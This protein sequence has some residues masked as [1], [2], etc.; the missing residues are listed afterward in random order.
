MLRH[1]E[2][3]VAPCPLF[4][5]TLL[6]SKVLGFKLQTTGMQPILTVAQREALKGVVARRLPANP[7]IR[8]IEAYL[9]P[10]LAEQMPSGIAL[11]IA[12][13]VISTALAQKT[14]DALV[15]IIR[16]LDTHDETL[17]SLVKLA[18]DLDNGTIQWQISLS[19]GTIDWTV[20]GDPL[21]V[22]DGRPFVD[23]AGFRQLLPRLGAIDTP[24]CI[25][26]KGDYGYGKSYLQEY[27]KM[28]ARHWT[29][30]GENRMLRVGISEFRSGQ[31]SELSP[32][33]PAREL[34]VG[35][36]LRRPPKAHAD[37]HRYARNLAAWIA[38]E[39]P[40]GPLPALA[41][42]D[43]Y[44]DSEVSGP[45]QT[46]I[47]ELISIVQT[48]A[49]AGSRLRVILLGYDTGRL[50]KYGLQYK[51]DKIG[52]QYQQYVLEHV[53]DKEIA[54]WFQKRHP[55]Q[56]SFRYEDAVD[57]IREEVPADGSL[58]MRHLCVMMQ[59]LSAEFVS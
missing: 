39:V 26:V 30:P 45:V 29:G 47:E 54:R 22:A 23:R 28:L 7:T 20:E 59:S 10:A 6:K 18:G 16:V 44:D 2:S 4:L 57:L 13:W 58:R 46:L 49:R 55:G 15:T 38:G 41:I 52:L 53:D 11:D 36:E 50:D 12:D 48:D 37:L 1:W 33:I 43:G 17:S 40:A 24:N 5:D 35:L 51:Q 8:N 42:F 32:G 25:V 19:A 14:C 27:L 3:P 21:Q 34:G 31:G 56:Q 9:P